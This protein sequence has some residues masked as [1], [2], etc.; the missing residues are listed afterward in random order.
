MEKDKKDQKIS[1]L[2]PMA[3][4]LFLLVPAYAFYT[5]YRN[6]SMLGMVASA[7]AMVGFLTLILLAVRHNRR[8]SRQS[9]SR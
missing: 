1:A 2:Y 6:H 3:W 7:V 8:L 5:S 4:C 9:G